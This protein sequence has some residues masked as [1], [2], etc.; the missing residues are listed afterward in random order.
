MTLKQLLETYRK[1]AADWT[2][3]AK[4]TDWQV[5][6]ITEPLDRLDLRVHA[7]KSRALAQAWT[8]A[9]DLLEATIGK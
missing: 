2:H 6:Q 9:A 3:T 4:Q 5:E 8:A 7:D 1:N